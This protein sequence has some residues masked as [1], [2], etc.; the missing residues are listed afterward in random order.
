PP[1]EVGRLREAVAT[2]S[3]E[4]DETRRHPGT[5]THR[6]K[7]GRLIDVEVISHSMTFGGR[8]AVLV[9]ANDVTELKQTQEALAKH[10]ERVGVLHEIDRALIA[11]QAPGAIAEAAIR[12]VRD[13]LGV[14]RAIVNLFDFATGQAEWLAAAGRRRIRVGPGVRYPLT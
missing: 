13:L 2:T 11:E 8:R 4:S 5:W 7:D 9:V 12:R 1:G 14:P 6:L 3:S 10:A